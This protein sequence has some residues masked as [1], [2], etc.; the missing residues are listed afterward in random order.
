MNTTRTNPAKVIRR[1]F[2]I[3]F[4]RARAGQAFDLTSVPGR[5]GYAWALWA[6]SPADVK[7]AEKAFNSFCAMGLGQGLDWRAHVKA[8]TGVAL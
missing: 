4:A 5:N 6:G 1:N 2:Q 8:T 3:G 7:E